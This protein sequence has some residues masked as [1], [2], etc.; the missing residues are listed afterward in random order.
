MRKPER[1][2]LQRGAAQCTCGG[3]PSLTNPGGNKGGWVVSCPGCGRTTYQYSSAETAIGNWNDGNARTDS[4]PPMS[5]IVAMIMDRE[6][7]RVGIDHGRVRLWTVGCITDMDATEA[8][9]LA[10]RLERAAEAL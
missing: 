8:R 9:E 2:A 1:L 10:D 3:S 7:V 6:D 5:P 4:R